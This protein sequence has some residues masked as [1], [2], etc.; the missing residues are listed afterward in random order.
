M[1]HSH[2]DAHQHADVSRTPTPTLTPSPTPTSTTPGICGDGTAGYGEFCDPPDVGMCGPDFACAGCTCA[3]PSTVE[4]AVDASHP[5]TRF[6]LGWQGFAHQMPVTADN[7]LTAALTGCS[8][9][10]NRPCGTCTVAGPVLNVDANA[11][12]LHNQR[13]TN[14][15]SIQCNSDAPCLGG[16]GTCKFFYGASLPIS[17][18]NF[19][20][21]FVTNFD[22]PLSGTVDV[23]A[24]AATLA[25][26]MTTRVYATFRMTPARA[27]SATRRR[28]MAPR[29]AAAMPVHA[30]GTPATRM[31]TYRGSRTSA[32]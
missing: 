22:D 1:R 32:R 9:G 18:G 30:P 13:C 27:A 20:T 29:T 21:C 14:D 24:G 19:G 25:M 28:T 12:Q 26:S 15:T 23:E 11:G 10:A 5:A 4:L 2:H 6:D 7:T 31:A 17:S 8:G 16:G 3:C